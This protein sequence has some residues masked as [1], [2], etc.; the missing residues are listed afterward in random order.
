MHRGRQQLFQRFQDGGRALLAVRFEP[1]PQRHQHEYHA[2]HLEVYRAGAAYRRNDGIQ[3]GGQRA[4]DQQE[5]GGENS[6]SKC[7]PR[8]GRHGQSEQIEHG[9]RE[10]HAKVAGHVPHTERRSGPGRYAA[11]DVLRPKQHREDHHVER[12][13]HGKRQAKH[14]VTR[15]AV[16]TLRPPQLRGKAAAETAVNRH[17]GR[18]RDRR[19]LVC[20]AGDR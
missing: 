3:V 12:Q 11:V 9:Q 19:R 16:R 10:E 2:S 15:D 6:A 8:F 13:K 20:R 18:F 1:A 5:I 7:D 17:M 14:R 4:D